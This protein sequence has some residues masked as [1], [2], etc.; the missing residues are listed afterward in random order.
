MTS[1]EIQCKRAY[2]AAPANAAPVADN[3][4][5]PL[6]AVCG[7]TDIGKYGGTP[8]LG[9]PV[10]VF[11]GCSGK[12]ASPDYCAALLDT[13]ALEGVTPDRLD[14]ASPE[15]VFLRYAKSRGSE[16][17]TEFPRRN[18]TCRSPTGYQN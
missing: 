2:W 12:D 8:V 5:Q 17:I 1:G 10:I 7:I 14:A 13:Q 4:I 3:R 16:R 18:R 6:P 11:D 15:Q 9:K